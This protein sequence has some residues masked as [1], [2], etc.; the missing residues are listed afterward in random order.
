MHVYRFSTRMMFALLVVLTVCLISP[1]I[2]GKGDFDAAR[3]AWPMIQQGA[4]LIDVRGTDE[5]AQGHIEGAI[6]IPFDKTDALIAAIGTDKQRPVVVYCRSGHRSGKAKTGLEAKG[7]SN[8]FNATG[9]EA[10]IA[11]KP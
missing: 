11:T 1:A 5:F 8:V 3:Q 9:L 4:L 2:A 10:L 6:N 7:Y